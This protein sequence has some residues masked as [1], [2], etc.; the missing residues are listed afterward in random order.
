MLVEGS[1]GTNDTM[2]DGSVLVMAADTVAA[3]VA[4]VVFFFRF[5]LFGH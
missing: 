2:V 3:I 5:F 1:V 4:G